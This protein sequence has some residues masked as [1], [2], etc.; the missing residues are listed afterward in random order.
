MTRIV[1]VIAT[2]LLSACVSLGGNTPATHYS[3]D[4][5]SGTPPGPTVAWQLVVG[6]PVADGVLSSTSIVRR[7]ADGSVAVYAGAR[8]VE[9]A[10]LLVQSSVLRAFEKSGRI[11]GVGRVGETVRGD[12]LLHIEL[13]SF[14]AEGAGECH[15]AITAKLVRPRDQRV[16]ATRTFDE[17][18]PI[19]ARGM[20]AVVAAYRDALTPTVVALTTWVFDQGIADA[21]GRH[22][23][24]R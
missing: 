13:V 9:P 3:L 20:A 2:L 22:S 21:D 15:V 14:E 7:D 1:S 8:W 17:R 5:A 24:S 23:M 19:R 4:V 16:V 12:F 18:A 11:V 10:P 6:E